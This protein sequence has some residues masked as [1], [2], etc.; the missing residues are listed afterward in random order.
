MFGDTEPTN[1][2]Q[3]TKTG[4]NNL[5]R[6]NIVRV[7][8][9][10]DVKRL[11]DSDLFID[12]YTAAY[13]LDEFE[14]LLEKKI[15]EFSETSKYIKYLPFTIAGFFDVFGADIIGDA[16]LML[17]AIMLVGTYS[18]VFLGGCSPIHLRI[19]V[20]LAG[21]MCVAFSFTAGV[22]AAFYFEQKITDI[23]SILPFLL[24][25]IGVDDMFV[26]C[27]AIDQTPDHLSVK[28]RLRLGM[29]HAGPSISITSMTN[30]MAFLFGAFTSLVGLNS[31]CIYSTLCI[32]FLYISV[33]TIFLPVVTWDLRR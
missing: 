13:W 3:D 18:F 15:K 29:S 14:L 5:V 12:E 20:A 16:I 25:G 21:L 2:D 23:H 11:Q 28:D 32:M 6:A 30:C 9:I 19:S 4:I 27:N 33:L 31:L 8:W 24:V 1:L 26:I 22:S 7:V 10:F 17:T